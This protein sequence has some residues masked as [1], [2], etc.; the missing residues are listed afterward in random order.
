M[1]RRYVVNIIYFFRNNFLKYLFFFFVN[2][3]D[4]NENVLMF[5]NEKSCI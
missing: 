5:L 3:K 1:I 2:I 4:V